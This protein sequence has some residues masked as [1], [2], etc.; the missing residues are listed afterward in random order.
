MQTLVIYDISHDGARQKVAD[1]CLDYGLDRV[2]FSAF[3]GELSR[4]HQESLMLKIRTRM[5]RQGG[6]VWLVP[7]CESDWARRIEIEEEG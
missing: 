4:N 1:V 5:G 3:L 7:I 2:Q 6:R